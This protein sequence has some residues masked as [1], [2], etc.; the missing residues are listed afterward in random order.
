MTV[1]GRECRHGCYLATE[2]PETT[3]HF[4]D[5]ART[6]LR[7]A[8]DLKSAQPIIDLLS[9]LRDRRGTHVNRST[10]GRRLVEAEKES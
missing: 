5:L 4:A 9:E 8:G 10:R 2:V 3:R 6:W 1:D 7:L